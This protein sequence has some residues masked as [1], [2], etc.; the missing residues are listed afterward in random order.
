MMTS[1]DFSLPWSSVL[2]AAYRPVS[3]G[4]LNCT[5]TSLRAALVVAME[6]RSGALYCGMEIRECALYCGYGAQY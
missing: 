1:D 6:R 5:A 4:P 3:T 2:V